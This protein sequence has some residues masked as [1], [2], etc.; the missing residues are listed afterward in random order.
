MDARR[1][2]WMHA[3]RSSRLL[4][5]STALL[6]KALTPAFS[7]SVC[8]R[9]TDLSIF[10]CSNLRA[11]RTVLLSCRSCWLFVR[12]WLL[13]RSRWLLI[14]R[15]R[16]SIFEFG[17]AER[18]IRLGHSGFAERSIRLGHSGFAERSIRLGHSGFA[19]RSIRLGRSGFAE[20]RPGLAYI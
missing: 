15:L 7:T 6:S 17:F 14:L 12:D 2:A 8:S 13:C 1:S 11:C 5:P 3:E 10:H 20:R 18:S 19:E 16:F 9:N 4:L